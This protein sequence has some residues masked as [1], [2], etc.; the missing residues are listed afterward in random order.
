MQDKKVYMLIMYL[1]EVHISNITVKNIAFV[2]VVLQNEN[3]VKM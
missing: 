2:K 3:V 1:F